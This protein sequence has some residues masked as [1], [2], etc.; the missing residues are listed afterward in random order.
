MAY[1]LP[2]CKYG[3]AAGWANWGC[4][5]QEAGKPALPEPVGDI[6]DRR[7]ETRHPHVS[8]IPSLNCQDEHVCQ[9][10]GEHKRLEL[11]NVQE[12]TSSRSRPLVQL[13]S[14]LWDEILLKNTATGEPDRQTNL[15]R[16]LE[17]STLPVS[18][19]SCE[20]E[21]NQITGNIQNPDKNG[22]DD[23][24][25]DQPC[26][27]K[28]EAGV[29]Q[30]AVDDIVSELGKGI[31][32][33][34]DLE[35]QLS[36]RSRRI[37]RECCKE[38]RPVPLTSYL[39]IDSDMNP[40]NNKTLKKSPAKDQAIPKSN[41]IGDSHETQQINPIDT[42]NCTPVTTYN[43]LNLSDDE[44]EQGNPPELVVRPK[45]RKQNPTSRLERE[46]HL[47]DDDE[48]ESTS[49]RGRE[50]AKIQQGYDKYTWRNDKE[51]LTFTNFLKSKEYKDSEKN[52][53]TDLTRTAAE[54]N[55]ELKNI[56]FW[57][58]QEY[59]NKLLVQPLED[60]DSSECSDGEWAASG[61]FRLAAAAAMSSSDES[62]GPSPGREER[63]PEEHN[64]DVEVYIGP[65]L[66]GREPPPLEEVE[67]PC[68]QYPEES[69]SDEEYHL[70]SEFV[71][72]GLFI[73]DGNNN[74]EDDSSVS[75][76][77]DVEWRLRDELNEG[78]GAAQAISSEDSQFLA[79]VALEECLARDMENALAYLESLAISD[80][81]PYPA[82]SKECIDHLPQISF[83]D[84]RNGKDQCYCTICFGEYV[85]GEIV[86]ELPCHH[87]FH[88]L[89]VT[90]WLQKELC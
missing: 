49:N 15:S 8:I 1:R 87:L 44:A 88:K 81:Q 30:E 46:T 9:H 71:H 61:P 77:L 37:S 16:I 55:K 57:D 70:V 89:C 12:E 43:E 68:L 74:L 86:T 51:E 40:S 82:A 11:N 80:Q 63:E 58:V 4:A 20:V 85:K 28:E 10:S 47:S 6:M 33:F 53:S 31:E 41:L 73:L 23:D 21:G 7:S 65:G 78:L 2:P 90:L 50:S 26:L 76:D 54:K 13:R 39:S 59:C 19:A 25:Q 69:S 35:S 14:C 83:T 42:E 32:A 38:V 84:D 5:G 36:T 67:F 34:T 27:G 56:I 60:E 66:G 45:I 17:T 48:S 72:P 75:E 64:T 24:G 79:F 22:E 29:F 52:T 62:S 18:L 3:R